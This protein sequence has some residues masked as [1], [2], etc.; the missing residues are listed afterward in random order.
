M[1]GP[2][3]GETD[4][5]THKRRGRVGKTLKRLILVAL[6]VSTVTAGVV[7]YLAR[8]QPAYWQ[9][10]RRFLAEST[11]EQIEGLA[12]QVDVQL[13]SLATL[14]IDETAAGTAAAPRVIQPPTGPNGAAGAD[15]GAG[16]PVSVRPEDVHI[17][18]DQTIT[19]N[20]EQLA[21]VV[22]TRMDEWMDDRG[23]IRPAEI[24]DPMI[25][26][27]NGKLVMAFAFEAGGFSTVISGKF[28]LKI[29]DDGMAVL[30]LKRFLVGNLPVPA[31]AIGEQLRNSTGGDER[32]AQVGQWLEKLQHLEFKPVIEIENRRRIRVMDYKLFE[33]GLELTVRVQDHKTY[34]SMNRALAGVR[35][36]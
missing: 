28:D 20:N 11:P 15:G 31:D 35:V 13:E 8:S 33:K 34:K 16:D 18:A 1:S 36:D 7:V 21:A 10:N 29:R 5:T 23:Y 27:D 30:S 6:L 4:K 25:A 2:S 24:T 3:S 26:V 9:E 22:Q 19:L 17:N 12:Q 14:G 32:A